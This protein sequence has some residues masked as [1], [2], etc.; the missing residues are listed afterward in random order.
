MG[1]IYVKCCTESYGNLLRKTVVWD[2]WN[3][4]ICCICNIMI[5]LIT[6]GSISPHGQSCRIIIF[7][8]NKLTSTVKKLQ[9]STMEEF[10]NGTVHESYNSIECICKDHLNLD[11]SI[12]FLGCESR[13]QMI[14]T[15]TT[16]RF[17]PPTSR[18]IP[19]GPGWGLEVYSRL[20][21]KWG[22]GDWYKAR[23]TPMIVVLNGGW[24]W[25][26]YKYRS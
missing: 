26:P 1:C 21:K 24:L 4:C 22:A 9:L 6:V 17:Y 19:Y 18:S 14:N 20:S 3:S 25:D 11:M 2:Q 5:K 8:Q 13:L 12:P 23:W 7:F 10:W 15:T 16:Y